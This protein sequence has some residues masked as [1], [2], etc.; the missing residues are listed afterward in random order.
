MAAQRQHVFSHVYVFLLFI[1]GAFIDQVLFNINKS[2]LNVL[3]K[4]PF[5]ICGSGAACPKTTNVIGKSYHMTS[6]MRLI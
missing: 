1:I 4:E 6:G 3:L 2:M 5:L